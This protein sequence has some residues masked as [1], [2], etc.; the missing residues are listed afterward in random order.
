MSHS[1]P[2]AKDTQLTDIWI[3]RCLKRHAPSGKDKVPA[4]LGCARD[5][6]DTFGRCGDLSASEL[7]TWRKG[8]S[9]GSP[10]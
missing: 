7:G 4:A 1:R 2:W 9:L 8:K 3:C 5:R 6:L 10:T